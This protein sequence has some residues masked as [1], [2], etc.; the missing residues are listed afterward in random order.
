MHG[1]DGEGHDAWPWLMPL[2]P[3][4][5]VP[6]VL[7]MTGDQDSA[8][9]VNH[10]SPQCAGAKHLLTFKSLAFTITPIGTPNQAVLLRRGHL[11]VVACPPGTYSLTQPS[12]G[13]GRPYWWI[14][15]G[16]PFQAIPQSD[17]LQ[18][19]CPAS[20]KGVTIYEMTP[21]SVTVIWNT[22]DPYRY[23]IVHVLDDHQG[24][25]GDDRDGKRVGDSNNTGDTENGDEDDPPRC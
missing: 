18:S 16:V 17:P 15:Q 9:D 23:C 24:H 19:V 5:V 21:F 25:R 22:R 12:A 20:V 14:C 8:H 13:G 4:M 1:R 6:I 3:L 11:R 7:A 2:S 10:I